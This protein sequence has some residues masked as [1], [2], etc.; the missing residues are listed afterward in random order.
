MPGL[1]LSLEVKAGDRVQRGDLIAVI[2][3]MKMR[4]PIHAP[5]T[6]KVTDVLVN[7]GETVDAGDALM[8]VV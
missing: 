1:V 4:R 6:G 5:R 7:E 8:V 2:E 3:A